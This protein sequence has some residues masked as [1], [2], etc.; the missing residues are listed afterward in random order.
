MA[1]SKVGLGNHIESSSELSHHFDIFSRPST[2]TSMLEGYEHEIHLTTRLTHEGPYEFFIPP[3]NDFIHLPRT[4]LEITGQILLPF[5]AVPAAA[6]RFSVCN[7]FPH[8]LFKQVDVVVGGINTSNQDNMYPFK[9][10]FE[11]LFSYSKIAKASH[12]RDLSCY[13]EDTVN[14]EDVTLLDGEANALNNG[15]ILRNNLVREGKVFNFNIPI[16]A[17]IFQCNRLIPP[18]TS[19]RITLTRNTDAFPLVADGTCP[20]LKIK[21]T[22][23]NLFVKRIIPSEKAMNYFASKLLKDEVILPFSRSVIKRE[24]I[25]QNMTNYYLKLFSGEQP[26]QLLI[27]MT[28]QNRL[29]GLKTLNPFVFKHFNLTYL[30]LRINGMSVPSKPYQPDFVNGK[31]ARELR[32]LYDN[33]GVGTSDG[34]YGLSKDQFINNHVF[35]A[36]DLTADSCNGYHLHDRKVGKSIDLELLFSAGN[37]DAINLLVYATFETE[38]RLQNGVGVAPEFVH[39]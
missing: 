3:S 9:A 30:N 12:L 21:L 10:Y 33:T 23:L 16:H 26:R 24:T 11:T 32:S 18:N 28:N 31:V 7:L 36:W 38:L 17:D 1:T 13:F 20:I 15:F 22:E 2:E 4:R 27:C 6:A 37:A 19:I 25:P 5:D 8:A 39:G 14:R 35:F 29:N 34:S